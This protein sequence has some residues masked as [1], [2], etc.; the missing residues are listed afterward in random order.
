MLA[1]KFSAQ[2]W[3]EQAQAS[4]GLNKAAVE[5]LAGITFPVVWNP[6]GTIPWNKAWPKQAFL[7][8]PGLGDSG[9]LLSSAPMPASYPYKNAEQAFAAGDPDWG[10][11]SLLVS[12]VG[13]IAP[14]ATAEWQ[15]DLSPVYTP[16]PT[17]S[18]SIPPGPSSPTGDGPTTMPINPN[19]TVLPPTVATGGSGFSGSAIPQLLPAGTETSGIATPDTAPMPNSTKMLLLLVA[20]VV[21]LYFVAE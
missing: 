21:V 8:A 19:V 14:G 4:G 20:A 2:W 17:I 6:D 3:N 5:R 12:P 9:L 11:W 7:N 1:E 18:G 16:P 15:P 13:R 10:G